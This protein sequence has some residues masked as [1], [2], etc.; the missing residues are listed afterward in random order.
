MKNNINNEDIQ[1]WII[2]YLHG[3]LESNELKKFESILN[4]DKTLMDELIFQKNLKKAVELNNVK[5]ALRN[6]RDKNSLKE[7]RDHPDFKIVQSK[8]KEA[9]SRNVKSF[10]KKKIKRN[11]AKAMVAASVLLFTH[12]LYGNWINNDLNEKIVSS[13][14][15]S[16]EKLMNPS[17]N[18]KTIQQVGARTSTLQYRM[19]NLVSSFNSSNYTEVLNQI[20]TLEKSA[21]VPKKTLQFPKAIVYAKLHKYEESISLLEQIINEKNDTEEDARWLTALLYL[22]TN[23]K[24][25]AKDQL[26]Y[27]A[28]HSESFQSMSRKILR[29]HLIL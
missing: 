26:D 4:S 2:A 25:K 18:K 27:L 24:T 9:N 14:D 7:K 8:I 12:F 29:K 11:L 23:N 10:K 22:K 13:T 20:K 5:E 3:D 28:E 19:E 21:A 16:F 15:L 6:A 17:K 1:D